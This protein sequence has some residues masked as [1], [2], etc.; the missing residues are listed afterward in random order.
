MSKYHIGIQ[1]IKNLN[2]S[3]PIKID[4][5]QASIFLRPVDTSNDTVSLLTKWRKKYGDCFA[6]KFEPT[7]KRTRNWLTEQVIENQDKI[8]FL[9]ILNN[10]KIGHIGL[11]NYNKNDNSAEID[12]VL[13][14]ERKEHRGLM[15]KVIYS[16]FDLGFKNLQLSKISLK[17]FE[18]NDKAINLYKRCGMSVVKHIPLKKIMIQDGWEWVEDNLKQS[19]NSKRFFNIMEIKKYKYEKTKLKQSK[20]K[21]KS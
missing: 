5:N 16:I 20:E 9:I 1:Q 7:E 12:N 15:E 6:T 10:K 8:L 14:G 11:F 21:I 3:I 4:D 19:E 2:K 17:V 18:D 13:R